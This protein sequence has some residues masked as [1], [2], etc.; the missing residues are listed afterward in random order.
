MIKQYEDKETGTR[1]TLSPETTKKTEQP[2]TTVARHLTR[3][4][5]GKQVR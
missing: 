4:K 1:S 2:E 5:D 3:M